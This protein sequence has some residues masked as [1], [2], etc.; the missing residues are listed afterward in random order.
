MEARVEVFI[1]NVPENNEARALRARGGAVTG[2]SKCTSCGEGRI[3]GSNN[4][5]V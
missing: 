1:F 5:E 4:Y 3:A 2:E